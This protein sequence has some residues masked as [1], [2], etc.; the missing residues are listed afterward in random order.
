MSSPRKH[1][2][3][4]NFIARSSGKEHD[5]VGGAGTGLLGFQPQY[6]LA[7]GRSY[8]AFPGLD[9]L[10]WED[11]ASCF[12]GLWGEFYELKCGCFEEHLASRR[13][14]WA[15]VSPLCKSHVSLALLLFLF[16]NWIGKHQT[17]QGAVF[18]PPGGNVLSPYSPAALPPSAKIGGNESACSLLLVLILWLLHDCSIYSVRG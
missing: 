13:C 10:V 12:L 4:K 2:S 11:A 17:M 8:W 15:V 16:L 14:S 3:F 7:S 6:L 1:V 18:H 5:K 9:F